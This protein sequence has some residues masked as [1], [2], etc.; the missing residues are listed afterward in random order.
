MYGRL[1]HMGNAGVIKIN[2]CRLESW[3][4]VVWMDLA[5]WEWEQ[6]SVGMHWLIVSLQVCRW[7][8]C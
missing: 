2:P 4:G 3:K 5:R 1:N 6:M 8:S 7:S